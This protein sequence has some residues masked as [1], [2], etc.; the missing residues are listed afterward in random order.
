MKIPRM[1]SVA[2]VV[3]FGL[4]SAA[5]GAVDLPEP[6][7]AEI[8][9]VSQK[10]LDGGCNS[11]ALTPDAYAACIHRRAR[12][13][14]PLDMAK[15]EHFGELYDPKRYLECMKASYRNYQGC[16]R[17]ELR[18]VE[19][20][21]YWP[22]PEVQSIKWPDPPKE[23]VYRAGMSSKDYFKALC[24][25]EEGEFIYKT[26]EGVEGIYQIRPRNRMSSIA[27]KDKYVL[28]DPRGYIST[29]NGDSRAE[30]K[31]LQVGEKYHF[32]ERPKPN[33]A[34]WRKKKTHSTSSREVIRFSPTSKFGDLVQE[35]GLATS[36][37]GYTWREI[38]RPYDFKNE[39]RGGE[40]AVVDL[41]TNEIL[42]IRRF[43]ARRDVVRGELGSGYSWD[44]EGC[45]R[46]GTEVILN[47]IKQVLRPKNGE[48]DIK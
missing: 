29:G 28:E 34:D 5:S 12:E 4:C 17:Y 7:E 8:A 39:V 45:P 11:Y 6:S 37:Y 41:G 48:G 16:D 2:G 21:E 14:P 10:M 27:T 40:I 43:F 32:L 19:N 44:A 47:F 3:A 1:A 31:F 46:Y 25:A 38:R 13:L 42:G 33:S 35:T 36:R 9:A 18:R 24:K 26:V 30:Y 15:R 22:Y 23:S 20:P